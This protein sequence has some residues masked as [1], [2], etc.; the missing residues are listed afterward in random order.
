[1]LRYIE[2]LQYFFAV[3]VKFVIMNCQFF[4]FNKALTL[5]LWIIYKA[6]VPS[7]NR[8][9]AL[10]FRIIHFLFIFILP[11]DRRSDTLEA[12]E[13]TYVVAYVLISQVKGYLRNGLVRL[14]KK[15]L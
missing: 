15:P 14:P 1:M 11:V 3:S 13:K 7:E 9:P 4:I 2:F 5:F 8:T 10:V 12:F 6:G